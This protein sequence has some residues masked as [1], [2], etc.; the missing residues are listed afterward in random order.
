MSKMFKKWNQQMDVEAMRND[1]ADIE[2]NKKEYKEVPCDTYEVEIT[3]LFL[4]ESEKTGLPLMKVWF[5]IKAG[6]YKGQMI[7]MTQWLVSQSGSLFGLHNANEFLK[8]LKTSLPVS[9][10]DWEA[11]PMLLEDIKEELEQRKMTFQLKY[12]VNKKNPDY[13]TYTIEQVFDNE[14]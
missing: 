2:S 4:D 1:L 3:K 14:D 12:G 13:K 5:K 6:E 11:Y 9:F 7:F 8:S 10:V